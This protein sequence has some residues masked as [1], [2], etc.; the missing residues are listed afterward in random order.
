MNLVDKAMAILADTALVHERV[1]PPEKARRLTICEACEHF[2]PD[3]RKCKV[4]SCFMDVKCGAKTNFNPKR[5]RN[6]ITHCPL[7]FWGDLETANFYRQ[8][9]GIEPLIPQTQN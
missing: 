1:E 5:G 9:D 8:K 6:E 3:H 7:A 2:D 4:C